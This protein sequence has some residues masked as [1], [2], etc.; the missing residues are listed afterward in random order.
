MLTYQAYG[1]AKRDTVFYQIQ[2]KKIARA[3]IKKNSVNNEVHYY[4]NFHLKKAYYT[5]YAQLTGNNIGELLAIKYKGQ[6][7][8]PSI[9]TITAK[10][11][12]GNVMVGFFK[13][14]KRARE[15]LQKILKV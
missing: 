7:I 14:E 2:S 5:E 12:G 15:L 1:Q 11:T 8:S 3:S 6:I 9:P 10:I 4:I 13:K